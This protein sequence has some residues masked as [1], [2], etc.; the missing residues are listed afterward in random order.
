MYD[1]KLA[2]TTATEKSDEFVEIEEETN[3]PPTGGD[4]AMLEWIASVFVEVPA[5][6]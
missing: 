1:L 4:A 5:F 2:H 6:V 3:S